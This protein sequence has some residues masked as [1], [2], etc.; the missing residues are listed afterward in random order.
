MLLEMLKYA[1]NFILAAVF[2]LLGAIAFVA[3][4]ENTTIFLCFVVVLVFAAYVASKYFTI[5]VQQKRIKEEGEY[6]PLFSFYVSNIIY[7]Y[8][9]DIMEKLKRAKEENQMSMF[10]SVVLIS[11]QKDEEVMSTESVDNFL[12]FHD[13]YSELNEEDDKKFFIENLIKSDGIS[14]TEDGGFVVNDKNL[15]FKKNYEEFL[16]VLEEM[17]KVSLEEF[18]SKNLIEYMDLRRKFRFTMD[19]S[20]DLFLFENEALSLPDLIRTLDEGKTYY[21]IAQYNVE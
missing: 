14:G 7:M 12:P 11:S 13:A 6:S 10:F 5:K 21:A 20:R 17:R 1:Y 16:N 4:G 18:S 9:F 2:V 3:I 15:Y 19:E 8:L